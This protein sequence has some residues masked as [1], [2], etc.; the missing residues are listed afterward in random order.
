MMLLVIYVGPAFYRLLSIDGFKLSL[1]RTLTLK[2]LAIQQL[3]SLRIGD[4]LSG[5]NPISS[6]WLSPQLQSR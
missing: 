2:H 3:S 4:N 1:Y 5:N 6:R